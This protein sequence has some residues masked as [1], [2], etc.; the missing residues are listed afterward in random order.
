[1]GKFSPQKWETSPQISQSYFLISSLGASIRPPKFVW[2][3]WNAQ[4]ISSLQTPRR[5]TKFGV[6]QSILSVIFE[7]KLECLV[8]DSDEKIRRM[9]IAVCCDLCTEA[10]DQVP[11]SII[12]AI[13]Q[14]LRD[15]KVLFLHAFLIV[16]R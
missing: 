4:K 1:L 3:F 9:A 12:E 11:A 16:R 6:F 13:G 5:P 15:K 7:A 14:R 8:V 2:H 10:L